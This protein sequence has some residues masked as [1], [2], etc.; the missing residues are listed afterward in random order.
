MDDATGSV[1]VSVKDAIES[2]ERQI[3]ALRSELITAHGEAQAR[4]EERDEAMSEV[5]RWRVIAEKCGIDAEKNRIRLQ[6]D[7][8]RKQR[9]IDD[10]C[11]VYISGGRLDPD[12][13]HHMYA[14][15]YHESTPTYA[16]SPVG[17]EQP[18]EP[19]PVGKASPTIETV[20]EYL[21]SGEP[22]NPPETPDRS[23]EV[24]GA[25]PAV[26][27]AFKRS[28]NEASAIVA[29]WPAWKRDILKGVRETLE[30]VPDEPVSNADE[31]NPA[32]LAESDGTKA[33]RLVAEVA[34]IVSKIFAK[35]SDRRSELEAIA[36]EARGGGE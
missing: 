36:S 29:E 2:R 9:C 18:T 6:D 34:D 25:N 24:P 10:A 17:N 23:A 22:G 15:I 28:L 26:T 7:L 11:R 33:L 31:L 19:S 4:M 14:A 16:E 12:T 27:L 30:S 13:A 5:E 21:K 8:A 35:D 20:A 3:A 1:W 32:T